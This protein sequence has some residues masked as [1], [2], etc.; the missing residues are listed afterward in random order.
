M[1]KRKK[2]SWPQLFKRAATKPF[3]YGSKS[4]RAEFWVFTIMQVVILTA[5]NTIN[6]TI[7]QTQNILVS[8][9]TFHELDNGFGPAMAITSLLGNLLNIIYLIGIIY[10][11][12]T[13]IALINRRLRDLRMNT[14][15]TP[16]FL[17]PCVSL[18]LALIFFTRQ[19]PDPKTT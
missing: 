1:N 5:L 19:S 6:F 7:T 16:I 8:S 17:I 12:I 4:S 2:P 13:S 3:D 10:F 18:I 14:W 15:L 9:L 11:G